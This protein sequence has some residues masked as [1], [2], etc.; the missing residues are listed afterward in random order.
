MALEWLGRVGDG[1]SL[2]IMAD[3]AAAGTP[4]T[5]AN[6]TLALSWRQRAC[7]LGHAETCTFL[8]KEALKTDPRAAQRWLKLAVAGGEK[9]AKHLLARAQHLA[10]K[11]TQEL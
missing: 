5:P 7:E 2:S 3:I 10:K 9:D 6:A 4:T 8:G 1:R 11:Q